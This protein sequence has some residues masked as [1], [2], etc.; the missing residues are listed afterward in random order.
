MKSPLGGIYGGSW[1]I[2]FDCLNSEEGNDALVLASLNET[3]RLGKQQVSSFTAANSVASAWPHENL[4]IHFSSE[5]NQKM[6]S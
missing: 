4:L 1:Q 5:F 2:L 6:L 3:S